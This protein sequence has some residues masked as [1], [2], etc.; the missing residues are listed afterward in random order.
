MLL[1]TRMAYLGGRSQMMLNLYVDG[2]RLDKCNRQNPTSRDPISPSRAP[3]LNS[4]LLT[5]REPYC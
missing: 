2:T 5:W 3:I 4:R 1:F